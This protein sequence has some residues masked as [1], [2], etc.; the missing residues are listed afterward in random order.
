[1]VYNEKKYQSIETDPE[2]THVIELVD[3]KSYYNCI[4]HVQEGRRQK[5]MSS[6]LI[7][8]TIL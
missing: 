7:F 2:T 3:K 6:L 8:T 5:L 1:M 4:T